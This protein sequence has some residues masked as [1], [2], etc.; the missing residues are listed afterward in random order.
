MGEGWRYVLICKP[1]CVCQ[2]RPLGL[3][4]LYNVVV[5]GA[6]RLLVSPYIGGGAGWV[7]G[8]LALGEQYIF[9]IDVSLV[10]EKRIAPNFPPIA[11]YQVTSLGV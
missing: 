9:R 10:M 8:I 5:N 3:L 1:F 7:V 2:I 4:L 11:R 6:T